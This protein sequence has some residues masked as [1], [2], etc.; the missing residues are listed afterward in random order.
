MEFLSNVCCFA[1]ESIDNHLLLIIKYYR[2]FLLTLKRG[3]L[4]SGDRYFMS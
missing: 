2:A 1:F 4:I 3:S